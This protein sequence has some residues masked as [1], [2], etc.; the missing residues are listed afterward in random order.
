MRALVRFCRRRAVAKRRKAGSCVSGFAKQCQRASSTHAPCPLFLTLLS[1]AGLSSVSSI[2]IT[3]FC[4]LF[5]YCFCA[6]KWCAAKATPPICPRS[7]VP[8]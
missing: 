1:V 4:F 2:D 7:R 6:K 8:S 3:M 5:L